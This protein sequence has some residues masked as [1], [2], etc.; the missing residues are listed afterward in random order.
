M[1]PQSSKG[2]FSVEGK[3]EGGKAEIRRLS[4]TST[5]MGPRPPLKGKA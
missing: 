2:L 1:S 4:P 3:M 5:I